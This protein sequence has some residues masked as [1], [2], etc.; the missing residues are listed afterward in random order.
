[1]SLRSFSSFCL[2]LA[3]VSLAACADESAPAEPPAPAEAPSPAAVEA[4]APAVPDSVPQLD[5]E[6]LRAFEVALDS[7]DALVRTLERIEG[8]VAAWNQADEAA[9]LLTYLEAN[10]DAFALNMT[11]AEA[12][13]RYPAQVGR[14]NALEARR[15]AELQRINKDPVAARVLLEEMAKANEEL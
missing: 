2:L 15:T 7:L 3:A 6:R 8:P 11:E 5:S 4:P 12:A 13:R 10:R 9:R 1:M 14:L